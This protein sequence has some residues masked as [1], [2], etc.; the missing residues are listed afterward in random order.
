MLRFDPTRA[1]HTKFVE[2]KVKKRK[3]KANNEPNSKRAKTEENFQHEVEAEP[4]SNEP[5]VSMDH[6]YEVRG[7]LKKSLGSGGF[8]LLSMFNRP[9]DNIE[10]TITTEKPYEEK[11]IAK[12]GVKF[13]ADLDPFKYDSS[14]D[15]ADID[16]KK[17][18][19]AETKVEVHTKIPELKYE[20]FFTQSLTDERL[21]GRLFLSYF[22]FNFLFIK[23]SI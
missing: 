14:G 13:L 16:D 3:A 7:D 20:S 12:N 4:V 9:A 10:Q 15:E 5:P 21:S 18:E 22:L 8:S 17:K 6:F 11:L 19:R 2:P 23:C 1:D